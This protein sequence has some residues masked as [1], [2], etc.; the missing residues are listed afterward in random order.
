M[1]LVLF[2]THPFQSRGTAGT[3]VRGIT[4]EVASQYVR[5][6][7]GT[8]RPAPG[9]RQGSAQASGQGPGQASASGTGLG[10]VQYMVGIV[11]SNTRPDG[12]RG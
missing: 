9:S 7:I 10:S 6:T 11:S 1:D 3:E 12:S 8:G 5:S 2:L 4:T